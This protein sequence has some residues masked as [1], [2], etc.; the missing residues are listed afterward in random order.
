MLTVED[1]LDELMRACREDGHQLRYRDLVDARFGSR[2]AAPSIAPATEAEYLRMRSAA[3]DHPA[4]AIFR[5]GR[6]T[7]DAQDAPPPAAEPPWWAAALNR[8]ATVE[9]LMFDAAR[10]KRPMPTAEELRAWAVKLGT[11]ADGEPITSVIPPGDC[12][13]PDC[14]CEPGWCLQRVPATFH[15]AAGVTRA[16][17]AQPPSHVEGV[18]LPP[19]TPRP[20]P[21]PMPRTP[22][23]LGTFNEQE[24]D[25]GG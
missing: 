12:T 14:D 7:C 3:H 16:P 8:R 1:R 5:G 4:C 25:H 6:C 10:G 18:N 2:A 9:Q 22:G 24:N 20:A 15:R 19:V 23:V 21:P 13:A 11:P 17:A